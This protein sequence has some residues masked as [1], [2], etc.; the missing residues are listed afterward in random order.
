MYDYI[1]LWLCIIKFFVLL[2]KWEINFYN[3]VLGWC[4]VGLFCIGY[5]CCGSYEVLEEDKEYYC[6]N[7][8]WGFC[9]SIGFIFDVWLYVD[10]S[11]IWGFFI[12]VVY[13]IYSGGG[14]FFLFDEEC[15]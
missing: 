7:W 9:L 2:F 5:I 4:D 3:F 11:I 12:F 10:L 8:K 13:N 1:L 14:Y 15:S 6:L